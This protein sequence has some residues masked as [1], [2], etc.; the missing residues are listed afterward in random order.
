MIGY[1]LEFE[2]QYTQVVEY[3]IGPKMMVVDHALDARV[4]LNWSGIG[5]LD[6]QSGRLR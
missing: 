6:L 5:L 1:S 2:V 4:N 3:G